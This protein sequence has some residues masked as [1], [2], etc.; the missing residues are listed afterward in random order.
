MNIKNLR[1]IVYLMFVMLFTSCGQQIPD[2]VIKPKEMENLLYDYHLAITMGNDLSYSEK[3][4]R[5]A[6][7]E[8]VLRK[9]G[10]TYA[11][12]DSSMVWYTRNTKELTEIYKNLQKRFEMAE[13]QIRSELNKRSGQISVS[14]SGDSVDV[15]SDRN[16]YWLTS[17]P[18]TNKLQFDL[19]ADTTFHKKDILVLGAD[20]NFMSSN[21]SESDVVLAVNVVF[22]NDST[23]GVTQIINKQG[24][25]E[26]YLKP[27]SAYE[28]KSV[29]GFIYFSNN[30]SVDASVLIS[31]IRL[32]RYRDG[33]YKMASDN[34]MVNNEIVKDSLK[35]ST[36]EKNTSDNKETK[37]S[38]R[39]PR[40]TDKKPMEI[41]PLKK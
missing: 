40:T 17:Y 25:N 10:V 14:L 31:N 12:F 37:Q 8:Y 9:H 28:Y 11:E 19:K 21:K 29:N 35:V 32:M 2:D 18:L 30:D 27:D 34:M 7:K 36:P 33:S 13:E 24:F 41:K 4:K 20:F 38:A 1:V 26:V 16:L 39:I 5:E 22:K 3:Y 15:W 6:Y 23:Q